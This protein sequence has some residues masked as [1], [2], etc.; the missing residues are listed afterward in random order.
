MR[1]EIM[2]GTR[3]KFLQVKNRAEDPRVLRSNTEMTPAAH[4]NRNTPGKPGRVYVAGS[5]N[6]R[7]TPFPAKAR[8]IQFE[9]PCNSRLPLF[10]HHFSGSK[11]L[12]SVERTKPDLNSVLV[13]KL[14]IPCAGNVNLGSK[15]RSFY[16]VYAFL[17]H[18]L[19][20]F[21]ALS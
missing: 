8:L 7:K 11:T 2:T 19:L 1:L 4:G 16:A 21:P 15:L 10:E 18:A 9:T 20:P 17:L 6:R 3:K 12:N 14:I 5:S 13:K